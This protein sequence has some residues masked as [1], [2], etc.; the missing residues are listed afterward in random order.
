MGHDLVYTC[1][2]L[3]CVSSVCGTMGFINN[4]LKDTPK[5]DTFWKPV[6]SFESSEIKTN[7][8]KRVNLGAIV[9]ILQAWKSPKR[10]LYASFLEWRKEN[11]EV[12]FEKAFPSH[13]SLPKPK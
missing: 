1:W 8:M 2:R 3:S 6:R 10:K 13:L 11:E 5:T 4:V 7:F 9:H 12:V